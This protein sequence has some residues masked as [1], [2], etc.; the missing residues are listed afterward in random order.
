MTIHKEGKTTLA[1]T[2]L[3]LTIF[4]YTIF[5]NFESRGLQMGGAIFSGF[6]FLLILQFFRKP[7][8]TTTHND[9]WIYCPADGKIVV[10][11]EVFEAEYFKEKRLQVSIFM[12]PFN[13]H[14][15]KYPIA[16]DVVHTQYYKGKFLMAWHPKS[17]TDNERNSVVVRHKNGV[18]IMCTQIAGFLAR[19]ICS[20]AIIGQKVQQGEEFGFI[21]FGSRVDIFLPV[22]T[23]LKVSL[24]QTVRA[25]KTVIAEFNA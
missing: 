23:P 24:D 20:Y 9:A 7:E 25:G 3:A 21:K 13:V 19:R 16:G 15:N 5:T 11:E 22:N 2:I 1:L 8:F 17:S 14:S 4:N 18:E 10:I 12:S 6:F